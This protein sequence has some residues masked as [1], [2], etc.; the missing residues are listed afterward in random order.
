NILMVR[1]D[2][3]I[4]AGFGADEIFVFVEQIDQRGFLA[5]LRQL[6]DLFVRHFLIAF[7]AHCLLSS[8]RSPRRMRSR[9][10]RTFSGRR[11][12]TV[13]FPRACAPPRAPNAPFSRSS[14]YSSSRAETR[15]A[16]R[17]ITMVCSTPSDVATR[18]RS[19]PARA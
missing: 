10:C 17:P 9:L 16:P 6:H 8:V 18:R 2:Q 1:A 12:I 13:L 3:K 14:S 4:A 5:R 11:S 15:S 7:V 19:R